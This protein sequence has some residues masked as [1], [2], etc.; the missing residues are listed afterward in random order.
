MASA[1]NR[2]AGRLE[3]LGGFAGFE[4]RTDVAALTRRD[5]SKVLWSLAERR[6]IQ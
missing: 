6:A 1:S 3:E 4:P 5:G 2:A